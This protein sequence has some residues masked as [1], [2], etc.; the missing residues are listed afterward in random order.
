MGKFDGVKETFVFYNDWMHTIDEAEMS[1]AEFRELMRIVVIYNETGIEPRASA[2]GSMGRMQFA[3][4]RRQIDKDR[5][6]WASTRESRSRAGKASGAARRRKRTEPLRADEDCSAVLSTGIDDVQAE[7]QKQTEHYKQMFPLRKGVSDADKRSCNGVGYGLGIGTGY[8]NGYDCNTGFRSVPQGRGNV[9][10]DNGAADASRQH[11]ECQPDGDARDAELDEWFR[12]SLWPMYPRHEGREA[13]RRALSELAPDEKQ[14]AE[15]IAGLGR[16]L[17]CSPT[18]AEHDTQHIPFL[19]KWLADRRWEDEFDD[20]KGSRHS[21][22]A[23]RRNT[24]R[25][26]SSRCVATD[27]DAEVAA[28]R[29]EIRKFGFDEKE[30][31]APPQDV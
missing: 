25:A 22:G 5:E 15:I 14:R 13:A 1:D 29:A 6:K 9:C 28:G 20:G 26:R 7:Q 30:R 21:T 24:D 12:S 4:M 19:A 27:W 10:L 31:T 8:G 23:E 18:F 16:T 3:T 11:G 2:L 17:H